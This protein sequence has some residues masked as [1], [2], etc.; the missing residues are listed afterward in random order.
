MHSFPELK[1]YEPLIEMAV[2]ED[3]G[4]GDVT[5]RLLAGERAEGVAVVMQKSPG[6]ACGLP[7]VGPVCRAFDERLKVEP[8]PGVP[9][10][11]A[12]GRYSDAKL[13]PLL[14]VRGPMRS[15]L[16]AER[17]LL[18]FL[19][20]MGGVATLTR[21]FVDRVRGTRARIVD[22]RKTRPGYRAL[23][24]YA[25]RCGGGANHRHGLYDMVLIKDNHLAQLGSE[26][27]AERLGGLIA[28]S[29]EENPKLPIEVEVT[30]FEQ[31][32]RVLELPVDYVLLDNMDLATMRRCVE[33]RDARF[34]DVPR[35]ERRPSSDSIAR[36]PELEASGG[37]NLD[38]VRAI[39][40]TG[41][42]RISVGAITH[43]A[44]ALDISLEIDPS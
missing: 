24:K 39:A 13:T 8:M 35:G 26:R 42:D 28:K 40:E 3:L 25:V 17:T 14:C 41:V 21:K 7:I 27:W 29:R 30:T 44:P 33:K 16:S 5:S 12:E 31:F 15:I 43:S 20:H 22:T 9:I 4:S 6:V 36:G 37:V 1:T 10:A 34:G 19:Q 18:N 32:D 23:D 38:T 2:R 11:Q